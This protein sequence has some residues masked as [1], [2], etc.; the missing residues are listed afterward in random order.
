MISERM[1]KLHYEND[2]LNRY[3]WRT[4]DH[5]E[6]NYIEEKA[7]DIFGF[8]FKWSPIAKVKISNL[9]Q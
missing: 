7:G 9:F 2:L 5:Q 8:E 6:I 3:F 4:V 1:K